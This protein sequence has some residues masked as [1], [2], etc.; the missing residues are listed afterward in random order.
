MATPLVPHPA[1]ESARQLAWVLFDLRVL[2]ASHIGGISQAAPEIRTA[3]ELAYAVHNLAP[4]AMEG[5]SF[6]NEQF[7]QALVRAEHAS[8]QPFLARYSHTQ[9][10]GG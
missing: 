8:G 1:D 7:T 4:L 2:L 10:G 5:R 6:T 3:A 9:H